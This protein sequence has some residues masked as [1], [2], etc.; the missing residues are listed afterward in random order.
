MVLKG[1]EMKL[2]PPLEPFP[3]SPHSRSPPLHIVA[4]MATVKALTS[5]R[6]IGVP[7]RTTGHPRLYSYQ[8][9]LPTLPVPAVADTLRRYLRSV[10]PLLDDNKFQGRAGG[11]CSGGF[12]NYKRK[13]EYLLFTTFLFQ[14]SQRLK[15]EYVLGF[16]LSTFE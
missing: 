12:K 4:W 1:K 13:R 8:G 9:A 15:P 14:F 6:L 16:P 7:S 11:Q 10:R 3:F 5:L 2:F